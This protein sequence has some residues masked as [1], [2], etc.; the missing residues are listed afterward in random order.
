[1]HTAQETSYAEK[2][3]MLRGF[4]RLVLQPV[5]GPRINKD[6]STRLISIFCDDAELT[7]TVINDVQIS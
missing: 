4:V 3:L 7:T 5:T 2:R 6:H 1:M